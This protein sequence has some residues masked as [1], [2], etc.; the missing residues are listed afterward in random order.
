MAVTSCS[1]PTRAGFC[2][3]LPRAQFARSVFF[4]VSG[5]FA[6]A[7]YHSSCFLFDVLNATKFCPAALL[8]ANAAS[9]SDGMVSCSTAS[10]TSQDPSLFAA[11]TAAKQVQA[12]STPTPTAMPTSTPAP[13]SKPQPSQTSPTP[14]SLQYTGPFVGSKNSNVYHIPSCFEA[15]KIKPQNLVTF[16]NAKAAQAAG[17]RPCEVCKPETTV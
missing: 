6:L 12:S 10:Y 8:S 4:R 17:Y 7:T 15:Q 5:R 11:S 2:S 16:P 14:S 9:R 1:R 13:T 3:A